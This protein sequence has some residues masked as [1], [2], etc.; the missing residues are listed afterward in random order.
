M[1]P[2]PCSNGSRAGR[3]GGRGDR[4]WH[5]AVKDDKFPTTRTPGQVFTGS[6]TGCTMRRF[7]IG[8]TTTLS[9]PSSRR[10]AHL[11]R[12]V[13]ETGPLPRKTGNGS[14]PVPGVRSDLWALATGRVSGC[15][16][17]SYFDLIAA[18]CAGSSADQGGGWGFTLRPNCGPHVPTSADCRRCSLP[19]ILRDCVSCSG[20]MLSPSP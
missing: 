12:R 14:G 19:A 10:R 20:L 4:R 6:A 18:C 9:S 13:G 8:R 11:V 2:A 3:D 1:L 16:A 15:L 17:S 5:L 7:G